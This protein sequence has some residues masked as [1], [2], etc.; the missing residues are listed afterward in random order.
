MSTPQQNN[1]FDYIIIGSGVAG[2]HLAMALH[3]DSFFTNKTIGIFDP[4]QKKE[5]DKTLSFWEIGNGKW[6]TI[7]SKKWDTTT[8]HSTNKSLNLK[9]HPYTY[10]T[11]E[12]LDFYNYCISILNKNDSFFFIREKITTVYENNQ[13]IEVNSLK[14]KYTANYVFDSRIDNG[15]YINKNKYHYIDQSFKGWKIKTKAAAFN[16]HNF[17]MMDYRLRWKKSTSFMYILPKSKTEALIE[18]TFFAPFAITESDFNKQLKDYLNI[19]Y[20]NT[21]YIIT[22]TEQGVIPM[23]SYPFENMSTDRIIKIGTAGGWVKGATGYSFKRSEKFASVLIQRLKANKS[24]RKR[25]TPKRFKFYDRLLISILERENNKGEHLFF[26]LY[27]RTNPKLLFKFL[28]EETN[29]WE[30][31]YL[32]LKLPY[33]PFLKALFN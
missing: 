31:I 12:A 10:K 33:W 30:E 7:V 32:I 25:I 16:P 21:E 9:L 8:F 28:D 6:D 20:P 11:I 18:Y 13:K 15:F 17:T 4:V 3:K 5:N 23:T 2:L 19:F 14:S 29:I 24:L 26:I 1:H 27:K 22:E